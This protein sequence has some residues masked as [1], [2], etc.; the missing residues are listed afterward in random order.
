MSEALIV[1]AGLLGLLALAF[2]FIRLE[3]VRRLR[4]E[5]AV[6]AELAA[7]LDA[8][9]QTRSDGRLSMR[10][11]LQDLTWE[12]EAGAGGATRF[13]VF[14]DGSDRLAPA[15]LVRSSHEG[16]GIAAEPTD[17]RFV[18]A[19]DESPVPAGRVRWVADREIQEFLVAIHPLGARVAETIGMQPRLAIELVLGDTTLF[20]VRTAIDWAT[21]MAHLAR[22]G[23]PAAPP[24]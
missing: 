2:S 4:D 23:T 3:R 13:M 17:F 1:L 9:L 15:T 16:D 20:T 24:H 12:L 21:R 19:V 8:E 11:R 10:G 6:W 5:V 22:E 7:L 18:F 14:F